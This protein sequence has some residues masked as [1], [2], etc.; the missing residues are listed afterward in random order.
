MLATAG[1][2]FLI[3]ASHD[4]R[5]SVIHIL[6][7]WVA[8]QVP[9]IVWR[10]RRHRIA[11]HHRAVRDLVVGALLVAGFFTFRSNG[12]SGT[13]CSAETNQPR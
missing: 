5:L 6:S 11:A 12:C 7:V 1:F 13:G 10:A 8:V 9:W 4:G 2:S 3:R